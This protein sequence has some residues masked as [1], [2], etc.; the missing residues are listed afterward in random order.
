MASVRGNDPVEAAEHLDED[1]GQIAISVEQYYKEQPRGDAEFPRGLDGALRAMFEETAA[2]AEGAAPDA[3]RPASAL[4]R[5][6][7]KEL[8]ANVFRWTGHFPERTRGLVRHLAERADQLGLVCEAS[9][10]RAATIAV[11]TL[12]TALA[13]NWIHGGTYGP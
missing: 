2:P 7:E 12:V 3:R 1:V 13:M 6:C 10:E 8:L 4:I 11:T 9:H 5:K